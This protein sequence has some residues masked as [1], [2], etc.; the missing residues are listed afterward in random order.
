MQALEVAIR[1]DE[2]AKEAHRRIN[3][4]DEAFVDNNHRMAAMEAVLN[5]VRVD[6]GKIGTKVTVAAAI[7]SLISGAVIAIVGTVLH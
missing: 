3:R 2:Q 7:A 6:V 4:H 1:A 5:A